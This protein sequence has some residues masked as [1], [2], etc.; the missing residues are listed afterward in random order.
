MATS[1]DT[2][3]LSACTQATTVLQDL[4]KGGGLRSI[5][6]TAF[7][8]FYGKNRWFRPSAVSY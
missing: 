7:G 4:A 2:L 5:F 6:Q 8:N 1:C 3:V